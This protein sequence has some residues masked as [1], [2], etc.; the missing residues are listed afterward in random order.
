VHSRTTAETPPARAAAPARTSSPP[1]SSPLPRLA[2]SC[3]DLFNAVPAAASADKEAVFVKTVQF[4]YD[5]G[6]VEAVLPFFPQAAAWH[7]GGIVTDASARALYL[8]FSRCC[9]KVG[10]G[11]AAQ[12]YLIRYLTTFEGATPAQL[13]EV[14]ERVSPA[15][16]P[17][18]APAARAWVAWAHVE[19]S[20]HRFRPPPTPARAGAGQGARQ[21][22]GHGLHSRPRRVAALRPAPPGSGEW[23]APRLHCPCAGADACACARRRRRRPM[24]TT[25]QFA[26]PI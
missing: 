22:G 11:D 25:N 19:P 14:S 16:L 8:L 6:Q 9:A 17:P 24:K 3:V 23:N 7:A 2:R 4:A 5:T 12:A 20:P 1:S 26:L 15:A 21:G 10:D 13:E 18:C